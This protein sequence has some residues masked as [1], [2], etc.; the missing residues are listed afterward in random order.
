MLQRC[1]PSGSVFVQVLSLS[2]LAT[3]G[4]SGI[5]PVDTTNSSAGTGGASVLPGGGMT[6][7]AGTSA[8]TTGGV[9]GSAGVQGS[10][11]STATGGS[12]GA[13]GVGGQSGGQSVG[14]QS[15]GGSA[16]AGASGA[17]GAA[18][19]SG[20]GGGGGGPGTIT[21]K[22]RTGMSA[23]CNKPPPGADSSSKFILHEVH[24]SG[25]DPVYLA[26]GM[27]A[28]TSGPY[29]LSFRP[30]G[31]KLP[32]NYNPATPYPVTFG[33]GGCGGSAQGFAS[34][35]NGGFNL[36]GNTPTIQV[37]LSYMGPCF[38]DGG[39]SIG[40]RPDSPEEPYFRAIMKDIEANYCIDLAQVFV[41][42]Y[43]SGGWE[44]YTLGCAAADLVRGIGADEGG[45]RTMHPACKG[46][47]A[48]VLVAGTAD[49]ENPIGPLD[50][51][52]DKGT[53]DRLGSLG[54]APGRDNILMR[55][56]C[57]GTATE[58]YSDP[59]YGACVKYSG[60][61]ANY[62]VIWCALPGVG[63]NNSSYNGTNYSPGPM[64]DVLGKLPPP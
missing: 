4:C 45:L 7:T 24:I 19:A 2:V 12:A 28:Q 48:A 44:S 1:L 14:G 46:P 18:G 64:W 40:N 16:G 17:A 42:G 36:A 34:N 31:V 53:I 15:V 25:L 37:G 57:V 13:Q 21:G 56:G 32:A 3:L 30:Y 60:C 61:P 38:N 49:T 10:G 47:V 59:K 11:G 54:S 58:P 5:D 8:T 50:P 41:G 55:N 26:G 63:H 29:D 52:A 6:T 22:V 43:S 27:Y 51:V 23:G 35:P 9:Q 20:S 33:G 39:P 62:P